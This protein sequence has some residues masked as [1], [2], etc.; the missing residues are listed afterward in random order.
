[1]HAGE[2]LAGLTPEQAEAVRAPLGPLAVIAGPGTGK[3]RVL[4]GRIAHRIL[5]CGDAPERIVG[6]TFTTRAGEELRTRT[7]QFLGDRHGRRARAVRGRLDTEELDEERR[8]VYVGCT[9][10]VRRL[11]L[12][13][14]THGRVGA[15]SARGDPSRL[16]SSRP[17]GRVRL[18]GDS[19]RGIASVTDRARRRRTRARPACRPCRSPGTARAGPPAARRDSRGARSDRRCPGRRRR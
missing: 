4:S 8:L 1:M 6:V 17:R 19:S 13:Y 5:A 3:T 12:N 11:F 10:A 18:R 9:R 15:A 7:A 2:I 14:P 16:P